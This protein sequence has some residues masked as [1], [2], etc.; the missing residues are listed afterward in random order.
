MPQA[1][2]RVG[3]PLRP[4]CLTPDM[5]H[6]AVAAA[7]PALLSAA[8]VSRL[9]VSV[10]HSR[11]RSAVHTER[12][13]LCFAKPTGKAEPSASRVP[14]LHAR[15]HHQPHAQ[16]NEGTPGVLVACS[17][18]PLP[19]APVHQQPAQRLPCRC[20]CDVQQPPCS[21]TAA[22]RQ[23][24]VASHVTCWQC[25]GRRGRVCD[26]HAG[27]CPGAGPLR[28]PPRHLQQKRESRALPR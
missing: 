5:L 23:G 20:M 28:L 9:G 21:C 18:A 10:H 16:D 1:F 24:E 25:T 12:L 17:A 4:S 7:G 2:A 6:D 27:G 3:D 11:G 26:S 13:R 15:Q 19:S 8:A 22:A 14:A